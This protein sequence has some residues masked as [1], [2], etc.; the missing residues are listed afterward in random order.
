M[1]N[2]DSHVRATYY[3]HLVILLFASGDTPHE[4]GRERLRPANLYQAAL[5]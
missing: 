1:K 2:L 5:R 4:P 3:D